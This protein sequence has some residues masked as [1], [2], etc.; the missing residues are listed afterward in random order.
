MI[1]VVSN[2][3]MRSMD[4]QAINDYGIPGIVLMENA[5]R[6][7]AESIIE[8]CDELDISKACIICGKGNNGG[9]GFVI[10]RYLQKAGVETDVYLAAKKEEI[11]GDAKTNLDICLNSNITVNEIVKTEDLKTVSI[12]GII[13]DALLGT[14]VKGEVKGFYADI[15]HW[16]NQ[17][18]A[19]ICAIDIPSGISGDDASGSFAVEADITFTMGMPKLSQFFYPARSCV[20]D[21]EVVDIGFPPQIEVD[22]E[23]RVQAVFEEDIEMHFPDPAL[24]KHS[25]GK[26]FILGG[27]PGLTGAM[28]LSAK[29]A[30]IGGAG[31]V[32]TG[33]AESLNPTM[34]NKLTEQMS[35]P[36]PEKTS[37]ILNESAFD[38]V[39]EKIDWCHALLLGPGMGRNAESKVLLTKT[40]QYALKK[41]KYIIIDADALFFLS[42]DKKLLQSLNQNCVITPHHAEFLKIW[43]EAGEKIKS[44]PWEVLQSFMDKNDVVTN[45]KG[46]PS[47]AGDRNTGIFINT[48]GNPGLAKGGS[49]DLLGGMI[50]GMIASGI[51]PL[52]AC[53]NANFIHGKAA[54]NALEK[55]GIRSFSP[56]DL[57]DE[58]KK[59]LKEYY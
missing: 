33:V 55:W 10:A 46:A 47:M 40:I 38:L 59:V 51:D 4:S 41:K 18:E 31:L 6:N 24:Y 15:I 29:G 14:G 52:T 44:Q 49:G 22:P 21:L 3:Q 2:S 36:L 25:A 1:K 19:F 58:I 16:I 9:D 43:P 37:G 56:E 26:V 54:D 11:K 42:Q 48:T 57:M 20:G 32:Y 45:L 28:V 39:K 23:I 30:S 7:T 12:N 5:G 53:I 13:V 27:S 8:I 35:I 34:E 17:Q 50:T